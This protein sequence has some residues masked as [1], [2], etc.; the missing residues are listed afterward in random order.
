M[1]PEPPVM[2]IFMVE[3][4]LPRIDEVVPSTDKRL[5]SDAYAMMLEK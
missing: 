2:R 1:K 4:M 5:A 3:R